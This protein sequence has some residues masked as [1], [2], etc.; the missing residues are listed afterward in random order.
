[1]ADP[2]P[3]GHAGAEIVDQHV[4]LRDQRQQ[5]RAV[6]FVL[7][8]EHDAALA[9][10]DAEKSAVLALERGRVVAQIIAR[11]G[12]DLEHVGALIGEQ[13][14]AIGPG[15]IGAEIEHAD[16]RQRPAWAGARGIVERGG[17][18]RGSVRQGQVP[19]WV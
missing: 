16:A 19:G 10:V 11:R 1:M 5:P 2:E 4:G 6:G 9:A 15:D 18:R 12:F 14:A 3:L 7:E 8:V 13:R 17:G